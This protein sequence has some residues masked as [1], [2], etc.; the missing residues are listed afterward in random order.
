MAMSL[1]RLGYSQSDTFILLS[2]K[3]KDC[4]D[5]KNR[6]I[7]DRGLYPVNLL[8][9]KPPINLTCFWGR[10]V[11]MYQDINKDVNFTFKRSW[12]EYRDGFYGEDNFWLGLEL[13]HILTT[14]KSQNT[15]DVSA[16]IVNPGEEQEKYLKTTFTGFKVDGENTEFLMGYGGTQY[17]GNYL[18]ELLRT[19]NNSRFSTYDRDNDQLA[20]NCAMKYGGGWWYN[21]AGTF[22]RGSAPN[23]FQFECAPANPTGYFWNQCED[24]TSEVKDIST[25]LVFNGTVRMVEMILGT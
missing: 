22:T 19:L 15:L 9:N 20:I 16:R 6:G 4:Q 8:P 17:V 23:E 3:T 12:A 10:T 25:G 11:V 18:G 1:M 2:V 7:R 24:C 13:M 21:N 14:Q 5:L